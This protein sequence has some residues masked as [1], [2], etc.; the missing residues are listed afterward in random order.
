MDDKKYDLEDR[1]IKFAVDVIK[2]SRRADWNDYASRYYQEQIIRSSGSVALNFG[3]FLGAS[4]QKDKLNKLNIAHKEIKE[5]RN[6][7][8]IQLGAELNIQSELES[9]SQESL[10]IIKILR[11]IIKSKS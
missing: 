6:N 7:L 1:L 11:S 9:L 2:I 8:L 4:S 5:C 3:E 10:E